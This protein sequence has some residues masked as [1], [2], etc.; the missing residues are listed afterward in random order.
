MVSVRFLTGQ[1]K[2]GPRLGLGVLV[3]SDLGKAGHRFLRMSQP[4]YGPPAWPASPRPSRLPLVLS[5]VAIV[6]S[7]VVGALAIAALVKAA[8]KAEAPAAKVY[9]EQEVADAKKAVCDAFDLVHNA[10]VVTN[11]KS[12]GSD[13]TAILAVAANA[14]LSAHA[15][16]EYL[17]E[18]L[19]Q[20]PATTT[21]LANSI[22]DLAKNLDKLTL[23]YL[24]ETPNAE[25]E[26]LLRNADD[27][28]ARIRRQ[29]S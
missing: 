27:A 1:V 14:R 8:P 19:N 15:G 22:R 18:V 11:N 17:A 5:I 7:L 2:V 25:Q 4:P 3:T 16:G 21:D 20:Y 9:S 29:C 12:G 13:P 23:E 28:T 26:P 6:L 10:I 24:G